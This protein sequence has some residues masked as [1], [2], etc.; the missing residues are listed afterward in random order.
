MGLPNKIPD[1][2]VENILSIYWAMLTQIEGNC[3]PKKDILDKHLVEGAY[4]VLNRVGSKTDSPWCK[5]RPRWLTE[6]P[7]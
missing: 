4:K 5:F 1:N 2:E 6:P 7:K 3:D